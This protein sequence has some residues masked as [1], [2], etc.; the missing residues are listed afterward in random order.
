MK[1]SI[2]LLNQV[3]DGIIPD[4]TD[5]ETAINFYKE[6]SEGLKCLGPNF[7]HSFVA[8]LNTIQTLEGYFRSRH[9]Q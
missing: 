8:C 9:S 3:R 1:I 7:H 2:E 5:L 6:M 4:N